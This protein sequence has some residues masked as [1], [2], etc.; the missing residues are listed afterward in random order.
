[1]IINNTQNEMHIE[2]FTIKKKVKMLM[3][4]LSGAIFELDLRIVFSHPRHL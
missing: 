3:K 1:M 2:E 4:R